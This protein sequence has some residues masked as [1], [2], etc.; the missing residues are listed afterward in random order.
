MIRLL[1]CVNAVMLAQIPVRWE[2]FVAHW[3][4]VCLVHYGY[5]SVSSK[6]YCLWT[7]FLQTLHWNGLSPEWTRE[8]LFKCSRSINCFPHSSQWNGFSPVWVIRCFL[9]LH[10]EENCFLHTPQIVSS[11]RARRP[12]LEAQLHKENEPYWAL[13]WGRQMLNISLKEP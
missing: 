6:C 12:A 2:H 5:E 8:C 9:S 3:A 1:A 10:L 4:L 11:P 7:V 13:K